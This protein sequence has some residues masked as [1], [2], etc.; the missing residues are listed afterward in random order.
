[1]KR[2]LVVDNNPVI[3]KLIS[4]FLEREGYKPQT[5][6]SSLEALQIIKKEERPDVIF[7]DM[8]MPQIS[9]GQLCH[10]LRSMPELKSVPIIIISAIAKEAKLDPSEYGAISCIAK[11]PKLTEH[12]LAVLKK[13]E[14]NSE[15]GLVRKHIGYGE[16]FQREISKELLS[17]KKHYDIILNNLDVGVLELTPTGEIVFANPFAM[18]IFA[19]SEEQLL[20]LWFPKIFP[21]TQIELIKYTL[22]R[23]EESIQILD[24]SSKVTVNGRSLSM[25]FIPVHDP[26]NDSILVIILDISKRLQADFDLRKSEESFRLTFENSADAIVWF[27]FDT[28][29]IINCNRAAEILFKRSKSELSGQH[30]SILHSEDKAGDFAGLFDKKSEADRIDEF[31]TEIENRVGETVPVRV[32]AAISFVGDITIV[33]GIFTNVS[34]Q[35]QSQENLSATN[36]YLQSLLNSVQAGIVVIDMESRT[37]VDI[38]PVVSEMLGLPRK[39]IVGRECSTLICSE[40]KAHC[41]LSEGGMCNESSEQVIT[42]SSGREIPVLRTAAVKE[43]SGQKYIIVSFIDISARKKLEER[44]HQLSITDEL[45]KILNRRGFI[46]LAEQQL[47]VADRRKK[48]FYLLYADVNNMKLINDTHGHSNGDEALTQVAMALK[49][50]RE[51]DIVGRLGGDEFAA[52]FSSESGELTKELITKRFNENLRIVSKQRDRNFKLT[53]SVGIIRYD[54]QNPCSLNDLLSRADRLMYKHKLKRT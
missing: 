38:N 53:I 51:S 11:G 35:M 44:L 18:S 21:E 5:A 34:G 10:I 46:T 20:S 14:G 1:M 3:L 13:L 40:D 30:R 28:G 43:I 49:M 36:E 27:N 42:D 48:S 52:L 47:K 2:I 26:P 15:P 9:G 6:L 31:E 4:C 50:F 16:V 39:Q 33:Q 54:P 19:L 41:R 12:I 37:I 17:V 29:M 32:S 25:S 22:S 24:E 8:V 45:T 23:L 7:T